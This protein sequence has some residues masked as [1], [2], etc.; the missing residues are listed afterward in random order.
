MLNAK[1]GLSLPAGQAYR[2]HEEKE[3]RDH[4]FPGTSWKGENFQSPE[5]LMVCTIVMTLF[6]LKE[7]ATVLRIAAP[8]FCASWMGR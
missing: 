6:G 5:H 1:E 7:N 8:F 2:E 3:E 4:I